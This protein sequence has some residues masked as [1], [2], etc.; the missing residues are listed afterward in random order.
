MT[1]IGSPSTGWE[2]SAIA[3]ADSST[4]AREPW[5]ALV[6][7]AVDERSQ[8]AETGTGVGRARIRSPRDLQ[9]IDHEIGNPALLTVRAST[10]ADT[11]R[12]S[13]PLERR[14]ATRGFRVT[15]VAGTRCAS[16]WRDE[17]G[18]GT[19]GRRP[20][21]VLLKTTMINRPSGVP[22]M[23]ALPSTDLI[24]QDRDKSLGNARPTRGEAGHGSL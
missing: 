11:G 9:D 7:A 17:R 14:M 2:P 20:C 10:L 1:A 13:P 24:S 16:G 18:G 12:L 6:S 21:H 4:T 8:P 23:N 19:G 5:G 22:P 3:T 15:R